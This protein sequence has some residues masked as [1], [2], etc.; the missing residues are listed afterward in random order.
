MQRNAYVE[1]FEW[2]TE[3][4]PAAIAIEAG[5]REVSYGTLNR[6]ANRLAHALGS[7][8][9]GTAPRIVGLFLEPGIA[10][11]GALLAAG[12]AGAAFMPLDPADPP[13][14]LADKLARSGVRQVITD[15]RLA[16]LLA[17][18]LAGRPEVA[19]LVADHAGAGLPDS[20]PGLAVKAGDP[21]YVMFTS[22]STGTPKAIL[23]Q[24]R[25]LSHF[26]R[27]ELAEFG[28][29]ERCRISWLAPPT[30]D[31]SLRDILA[32]LMAGGCLCIP[33]EPTARTPR[34]L[35]RW[36]ADRRITL[37]HCVPTVL[38]LL[39]QELGSTGAA[40]PL[41]DLGHLLVAGEPLY[42]ADVAA[43][44]AAAGGGARLVNLYGPSETTLAKLFHRIEDL[45]ADPRRVLP[46]GRPLPN[47]AVLI[48]K[49]G[50][51]CVVGEIGEIHIQ[52]P[53]RSLGYLGDPELTAAAFIAHPQNPAEPEPL[54]RTGDLGRINEQGLVE[55]LG[56]IDNQVKIRG[57]RIELGEIEAAMR[58]L[59]GVADAAVTVHADQSQTLVCY[60][61]GRDG[62]PPAAEALRQGLTAILPPALHPHLFVPLALLPR[63]L[64]GKINRKALPRPEALFYQQHAFAAP[65]SAAEERLCRIWSEL[66]GMERIG[67]TTAFVEF[68][69]DSL[70]A[71]RALA[72]IYDDFGI[73]VSLRDFFSRPTI[74]ALAS[75]L[76]TTAQPAVPGAL[77]SRM[78]EMPDYPV[79]A[80]QARLWTLDRMGVAP[81]AY[82]LAE[83]YL[84][85]G[86]LDAEALEQAFQATIARHESL[87][88]AFVEGAGG[89]PRQVVHADP[90]WRMERFAMASIEEAE[91]AAAANPEHPFDLSRPTQLRVVL[92]HLPA[93]QG[94]ERHVLLFNIHHIISDVWSLDLLV[95]EVAAHY[96]ARIDTGGEAPLPP[97]A[98]HYRDFAGWQQARL[99]GPDA[100]AD[101]AFWHAHLAAPRPLLDLPT[102]LPRPVMQTF[103]GATLHFELPPDNLAALDRLAETRGASRFSLLA[104]LTGLLLHRVTGQTDLI[105]GSP[106]LGRDQP[107]LQEQ[108]GCFVN[109]LALRLRIAS[110]DSFADLLARMAETVGGALQHQSFPFDALLGELELRRDISRAPLFDVM[111]VL[112]PEDSLDLTLDGIAVSPF[113]ARNAWSFSRYDL[114]FHFMETADGLRL[115]LNYNTDLFL[116][117]RIRRLGALWLEAA[118][119]A[120]LAPDAPLASQAP[121]PAQEVTLLAELAAG[122]M[123]PRPQEATMASLVAAQALRDPQA[124]A[125][126]AAGQS[127]SYGRLD[128]AAG[129]IARHLAE[130]GIRRGD[131]V[132]V[133]A[134]PSAASLAALLGI[135]YAGAVYVPLDSTLPTAR[136][137]WMAARAGCRLV[138]VDTADETR[139][140]VGEA[141]AV[142]AI[143]GS[144]D[145]AGW[146]LEGQSG[147]LD[148]ALAPRPEDAAYLIF[149]SGST[150]EPKPVLVAHGGFVNMTLGQVE[151]L[152]LTTTDRVLQFASPGFDAALA[153]LFMAW[154]AGGAVVTIERAT[155]DDP[156]RFLATLDATKCSVV[157]LPPTYLRML[158]HATLGP[159]QVLITAGEPAVAGD[160]GH[161]ANHLRVFNAYGP[162]E[163][164]VCATMHRVQPADGALARI[165]I[166]RPLPNVTIRL[167]DA[168]GRAV[169][170][171]AVGEIHIGGP[172]V[173]LGYL[174]DSTAT[175]A[176][177]VI[178]NSGERLYRSG[179]L[180]RWR[181]DGSLDFLGRNDDQVKVNG[182]RLEPGEVAA[183]LRGLPDVADAHVAG[184][185]RPDGSTG[186]AAWY[187]PRRRPELW[188]SVAEFYI[189]DDILYGSMAADTARNAAYRAAF[190]RHL[191]GKTVLEIGPGPL[192]VLSRLAIEAGAKRVYA[193][194]LLAETCEKARRT[195]ALQGLADRIV[196]LHGDLRH[197]A[198]PEPADI[199]ISEIVGAIGGSEGAAAIINSARRLLTDPTAMLPRRSLT[200]VAAASLPD[201]LLRRAFGKTAAHY[202]E[203]IFAEVGRPFDLRLCVKHLPMDAILSG[204]AAFEDLDFTRDLPLEGDHTITLDVTR[205]GVMTG[206]IVWL[207]L[208]I[209][210]TSRF[211]IL[212]SQASWLPV[213]LPAFPEGI[214]VEPGDR[215]T[216]TI[217][218]RLSVNRLNPDFALSGE[219]IRAGLPPLAWHHDSPHCAQSFRA[220]PFTQAL[221]PEGRIATSEAA[222]TA[223]LRSALARQLPAYAV[224]AF[225][226]PVD[227]LPLTANGKVDRTALP[228][229]LAGAAQSGGIPGTALEA[230]ILAIWHKV[231][232]REDL[233]TGDDF[234]SH[235]G[236]SIRAIQI[237]AQLYQAGLKAE[238]RDIFQNPTVATF[239]RRVRPLRQA[240]TQEPAAGPAPLTAIQRWFFHTI[241]AAPAH[242]LVAVLLKAPARLDPTATEGAVQALWRHHDA[243]RARFI[244]GP[245]TI[246]QIIDGPET[247][248]GF[249]EVDPDQLPD[250]ANAAYGSLSLRDGPLFKAVLA[251]G[252]GEAGGDAVLLVAHHLVADAVSWRFLLEDFIT[253]YEALRTG[254]VPN[255]PRKTLS[256]RDYARS[257]EQAAPA[258]DTDLADWRRLAAVPPLP[259]DHPAPGGATVAD[260]R[261]VALVIPAPET[262]LLVAAA[263]SEPDG[264]LQVL[265]LATLA[266][267]LRRSFGCRR[268]LITVEG[269]GRDESAD[270]FDLTRTVGW[271]TVFHPLLLEMPE[272]PILDLA[273]QIQRNLALLRGRSRAYV[274]GLAA[275]GAEAPAPSIGFNYLG[276]FGATRRGEG[277]AV[278]WTPPGQPAAPDNPR[279]HPI[280]LLAMVIDGRLEIGID[281]DSGSFAATTIARL[282]ESWRAALDE[283]AAGCRQAGG[284]SRLDTAPSHFP[285]DQAHLENLLVGD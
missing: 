43:W 121:L 221:F 91:A 158:D 162:T 11:V 232:G 284:L 164:S 113:G 12:K 206:F 37:V 145:P 150:G 134:L 47:T 276:D 13:A 107:G 20:N 36:L 53:Y 253:A 140:E 252:A 155:I 111:V 193:V 132:G 210:E 25:G 51:P 87:R 76:A 160:L 159:V 26:L 101:R 267:A 242:F 41:P 9:A 50:K 128:Q 237:L 18:P 22:G 46:I 126:L 246:Q 84:L 165:P 45:P 55:C 245:P 202:V 220:N 10:Y 115:D 209:D 154:V 129:R 14:R 21:C 35:I 29:D 271:F 75:L 30:F 133:Q 62:P 119:A 136:L 100:G 282:A 166:G 214:Q 97:L 67:V 196:V 233:G 281:Y 59:P 269:H 216:A 24:Q 244:D 257:E 120:A 240:A 247:R 218:R 191:A 263:H 122:P 270:E 112:Q 31:V 92:I 2:Q 137:A 170:A 208:E 143:L 108:I 151:I 190:Q 205:A 82:N 285:M 60:V 172:G 144:A 179:D 268:A 230:T 231:L 40:L 251:R 265:L 117:A 225:L 195:V 138:L 33:D 116:P 1:Q 192:A 177:F 207:T 248:A 178:G 273:R 194:E 102:D 32:P 135:L 95:R 266:R 259:V 146:A 65:E 42:G 156:G 243:L 48:L 197:I 149:T 57:I 223:E 131:R 198:L 275:L 254:E 39:T 239:A 203:R 61:T 70:K 4:R 157:T 217:R 148:A 114:V 224:P 274:K 173:A 152:G 260:S 106:V 118:E 73:E 17:E 211:D 226:I 5:G 123:R 27:W 105:L 228:D 141:A 19:L 204:D 93:G 249:T 171:G 236:D 15:S 185:T 104:A 7:G 94:I 250:W 139:P 66:F 8:S 186:L 180:G 54:Y 241:T 215:I 44:R 78:P 187:V 64:S 79:S 6:D 183:A 58:S 258:N 16:P 278:E 201:E 147:G 277:I 99:S 98:L 161:Y 88:T 71:M 109:E 49:N 238:I 256:F 63:T 279:I 125:V 222:A 200:R 38:R 103:R 85:A 272:V 130:R 169:P 83:A 69:G 168:A 23:G 280:D 77:I 3:T 227:S 90:A 188:P 213:Y 34:L 52:T 283:F 96:R 189:Y 28:L 261:S 124:L 176:R 167:L 264:G 199:C 56:R 219:V 110:D 175:A 234:F 229:P 181:E 81:T 74:R 163:I 72:R 142:A 89:L 212:E 174:G 255:L 86:P 262:A 182:H 235:G 68:G 184:L 153:N 80:V 127:V